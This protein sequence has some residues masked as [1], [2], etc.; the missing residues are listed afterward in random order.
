MID[1]ARLRSVDES[2]DALGVEDS[3]IERVRAR[4]RATRIGLAEADEALAALGAGFDV[5][6]SP[7]AEAERGPVAIAAE[8]PSAASPAAFALELD[9]ETSLAGA[10]A[11]ESSVAPAVDEPEAS[12]ELRRSTF[13]PPRD[14]EHPPSGSI[15][16][17]PP[18]DDLDAELASI[19]AEE[20][21][22]AE[23]VGDVPLAD[24][25]EPEPTALFSADMFGATE[26]PSLDELVS[27]MPPAV[28]ALELDALDIDIEEEEVVEDDGASPSSYS[29]APPPPSQMPPPT[30]S[31]PPP[32]PPKS[33]APGPPKPGF[34][35][36]LLHKKP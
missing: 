18:A 17:P 22:G 25:L 20:L 2:L 9:L 19:L 5:P 26:E 36:R 21:E 15:V 3:A 23:Q 1:L 4:V 16:A 8:P 13:P 31:R 32:P 34:L 30:L 27:E 10:Q 33:I 29:Q 28:D 24:D 35:G 11:P 6:P 14:A 7:E 12:A